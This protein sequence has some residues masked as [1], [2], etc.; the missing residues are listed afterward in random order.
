MILGVTGGVGAG[1]SLILAHLFSEYG[2]KILMADEI[3]RSL[4]M[5]GTPVTE[6][7]I[8]TFGKE[9]VLQDG[10]LDR[11]KL[12][13]LVFHDENEKAKLNGI[14]HPAVRAVVDEEAAGTKKEDLLVLESAILIESGF[15][16]ICDRIWYIYASEDVRIRRLSEFRG[17]PEEKSRQIMKAQLPEEIMRKYADAVI[18]NS[19]DFEDTKR[20][21]REALGR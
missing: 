21:I 4:M 5:P 11:A 6:K 19:G 1:K 10:T 8:E 15:G 7:I 9:Y 20:Q 14:V 16:E 2:A 18:D 12:A 17:Y 13:D 3:G